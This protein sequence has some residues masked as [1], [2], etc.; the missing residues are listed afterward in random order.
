MF[1]MFW[2]E[3]EGS[4]K[5]SARLG[6]I[7]RPDLSLSGEDKDASLVPSD[8]LQISRRYNGKRESD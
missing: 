5:K 3:R 6:T 7:S 1:R 2:N 8:A 4:M